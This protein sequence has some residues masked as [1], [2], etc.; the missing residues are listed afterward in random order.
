MTLRELY[1]Q[2]IENKDIHGLEVGLLITFQNG[3]KHLVGSINRLGGQCNDCGT[4]DWDE[5][6]TTVESILFKEDRDKISK[7]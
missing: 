5:E 1:K 4:G 3:T 6:I 2:H 7:H